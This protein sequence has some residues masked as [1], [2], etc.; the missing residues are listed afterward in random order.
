M[1]STRRAIPSVPL[2]VIAAVLM[3]C[4]APTTTVNAPA[5]QGILVR[6]FPQ[7]FTNYQPLGDGKRLWAYT[8]KKPG[9]FLIDRDGKLLHDGKASY[10]DLPVAGI[11]TMN[12]KEDWRFFLE[13][14][15]QPGKPDAGLYELDPKTRVGTAPTMLPAGYAPSGQVPSTDGYWLFA[16]P[17][18]YADNE[19]FFRK[20]DGVLLGPW[21]APRNQGS[22][23]GARRAGNRL[24]F[25]DEF[26]ELAESGSFASPPQL[27]GI[28][29]YLY[30][31]TYGRTRIIV[32]PPTAGFRAA[33]PSSTP[34]VRSAGNGRWL[35][36]VPR[37]HPGVVRVDIERALADA[38]LRRPHIPQAYLSTRHLF[39]VF[40]GQTAWLFH[41]K[42]AYVDPDQRRYRRPAGAYRIALAADNPQAEAIP[43]L[44]HEVVHWIVPIDEQALL[45]EIGAAP[46]RDRVCLLTAKGDLTEVGRGRILTQRS[47]DDDGDD[48]LRADEW[49]AQKIA[50]T[51]FLLT[52]RFGAYIL[53]TTAK[54]LITLAPTPNDR[55]DTPDAQQDQ[56]ILWVRIT[57][58]EDAARGFRI[59]EVATK[60]FQNADRP[61][62][63]AEPTTPNLLPIGDAQHAIVRTARGESYLVDRSAMLPVAVHFAGATLASGKRAP[64]TL[65][66]DPNTTAPT[67]TIPPILAGNPG[68]SAQLVITDEDGNQRALFE[69]P[70]S[71]KVPARIPLHVSRRDAIALNTP[72]RLNVVLR[73]HYG[74][75]IQWRLDNIVFISPAPLLSRRDVRSVL[76]FLL[77]VVLIAIGVALRGAAQRWAPLGVYALG[78]ITGLAPLAKDVI[79]PLLFVGLLL[80]AGMAA[81]VAGLLAPR[82]LRQVEGVEPF[83]ALLPYALSLRPYRRRYYAPYVQRVRDD[84]QLAR[85]SARD[86]VYAPLPIRTVAHREIELAADELPPDRLLRA[87]SNV[88]GPGHVLIEAEGGRGKSALLR[89]TATRAM[90]AFA[91]DARCSLPILVTAEEGSLFARAKE[92]LGTDG[93]SD[94][95][96][97]AQLQ[98]GDFFLVIDGLTEASITPDMLRKW[99]AEFGVTAPLLLSSRSN[100]R[101]RAAVQTAPAWII[102][103]PSKLDETGIAAF[104]TAY[105]GRADALSP[106]MK[107]ACRDRDGYYSPILV[108]LALLTDDDGVAS[109]V[110]VYAGAVRQ[111]VAGDATLRDEAVALCMRTYWI[112]GKRRI[113][114]ATAAGKAK[115]VVQRLLTSGLL[116][117]AGRS[118]HA[119]E[120]SSVSFFHDSMQD[121]LTALGCARLPW[122]DTLRRAAVAEEFRGNEATPSSLLMMCAHVFEPND[123]LCDLLRDDL[124]AWAEEHGGAFSRDWIAEASGAAAAE[125]SLAAREESGAALVRIA[126]AL[127]AREDYLRL[128]ELYARVV[129]FLGSKLS[130]PPMPGPGQADRNGSNDHAISGATAQ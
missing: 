33:S 47:R 67:I 60:R 118:D 107:Q 2:A 8:K 36:I 110:S 74:S 25:A 119:G 105:A 6:R 102:V 77:V 89:A 7:Q 109:L 90:D 106:A 71:I 70:P 54:R 113:P 19:I 12:V 101:L 111:L 44:A 58:P 100:E 122:H 46:G 108:R 10:P 48:D 59:Y 17:E 117:P 115:E 125:I 72:Y 129:R 61:L 22:L 53:D 126:Q 120:P 68:V 21:K 23:Y 81:L 95:L 1:P 24:V 116:V 11:T 41:K 31:T 75:S 9:V 50:D 69:S 94:H 32:Q 86:E 13:S 63:A 121:Y 123:K 91:Q 112:D 80:L 82:V 14:A 56:N 40:S 43:A 96:T 87:L 27:A 104:V 16:T 15:G 85:E 45:V 51:Q 20:N 65:R 34:V 78:G 83:R 28:E 39:A 26:I 37:L 99:S 62:F 18:L 92:A 55:G 128:A 4:T 93:F 49:H 103:E 52:S 30:D 42:A 124:I 73:D 79:D 88:H 76:A 5:A 66:F 127:H 98:A 29:L 84:L 38:T 97:H 57:A 130:P 64:T 114:Y 35:W 3:T